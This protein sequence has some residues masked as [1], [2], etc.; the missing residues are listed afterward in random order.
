MAQPV[1]VHGRHFLVSLDLLAAQGCRIT[2]VRPH[3]EMPPRLP[4][5]QP[6]LLQYQARQL[7]RARVVFHTSALPIL[8]YLSVKCYFPAIHRQF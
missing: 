4:T 7:L 1:L 8:R 5:P 6:P 3:F 2:H